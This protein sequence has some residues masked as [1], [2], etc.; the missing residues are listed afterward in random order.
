MPTYMELQEVIRL[1]G[2]AFLVIGAMVYLLPVEDK[3]KGKARLVP[4]CQLHKMP[5]TQC[6]A[7]HDK[8]S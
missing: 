4:S 1:L 7:M 6:A 3:P 8:E 5:I 2:I